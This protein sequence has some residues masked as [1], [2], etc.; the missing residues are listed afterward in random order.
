[1]VDQMKRKIYIEDAVEY[2]ALGIHNLYLEIV[3]KILIY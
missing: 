2:L 3:R 1:M